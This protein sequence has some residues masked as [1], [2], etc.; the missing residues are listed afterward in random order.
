[1]DKDT[2]MSDYNNSS[3]KLWRDLATQE[4]TEKKSKNGRGVVRALDG[5]YYSKRRYATVRTPDKSSM[6]SDMSQSVPEGTLSNNLNFA[7]RSSVG[8]RKFP[9]IKTTVQNLNL[10]CVRP[11]RAGVIIYTVVEGAIFFGLG[12]DSRSHDLTDSGGGVVYKTD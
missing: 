9:V 8:H 7:Y 11:Q 4:E 5:K 6:R 2:S 10:E 1:M 12:L 3:E